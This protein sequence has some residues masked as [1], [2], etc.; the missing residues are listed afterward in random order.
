M[1]I[2]KR[3][4]KGYKNNGEMGKTVSGT[5]IL[6]GIL[7]TVK[8]HCHLVKTVFYHEVTAITIKLLIWSFHKFTIIL[9]IEKS[10]FQ[11]GN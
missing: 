10:D 2:Y 1:S 11:F 3:V 8:G 5:R 9:E 6:S 4:C 7:F